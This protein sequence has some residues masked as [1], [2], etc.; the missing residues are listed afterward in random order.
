MLTP[1]VHLQV[2]PTEYIHIA[3]VNHGFGWT[4]QFQCFLA[5]VPKPVKHGHKP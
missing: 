2:G 4:V 5:E 1:H 3:P